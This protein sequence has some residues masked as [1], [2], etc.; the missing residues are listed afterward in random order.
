VFADDW[1]RHP[2]SCQHIIRHLLPKYRV[3]WVNTIGMRPP[4]LDRETM[5]RGWE[6]LRHW[7]RPDS[8]SGPLPDNLEVFNPRM[9]PWFS[10]GHDR[11]IN[12]RLLVR[13]L[14]P[15]IAQWPG[16]VTAI[17]TLPLVADLVDRLP[18]A[19]WVY[20]CVDD[21]S[22]WPGVDH[23][24]VAKMEELLVRRADALVAASEAL[25]DRLARWGRAASLL[26]HGVELEHWRNSGKPLPQL[27][28]LERPLVVFWGLLDRR[29]DVGFV[30]QLA[31]D[32]NQG[33]LLLVG[34]KSD[35]DPALF[36]GPRVVRLP[37][38]RYHDLPRLA[39]AAAVLVMP[40][41]DLPVTRAMQPLK[42]TE[43]LATG[44]PIVARDLPSTRAW[45]GA[46]DLVATSEEFS[47]AVRRRLVEGLAPCQAEAR[48]RLEQESWAEKARRFEQVVI[49]HVP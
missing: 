4:R 25:Q 47:Q 30:R 39:S 24:A 13:Q 48:R 1:G 5:T 41:A 40:Y 12:R 44:K 7:F 17:T 3:W 6:K 46:L 34:P 23:E 11:R 33:T 35:P 21:F 42:L 20:Y 38:V 26:T 45:A 29:M 14:C 37:A 22:Q 18:V 27:A 32:L 8:A 28:D 15:L 10:R 9:W 19:R 36:Q 49:D 2:S 16:P 31:R 43:Y